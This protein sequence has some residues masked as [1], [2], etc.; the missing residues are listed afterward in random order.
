MEAVAKVAEWATAPA[1]VQVMVPGVGRVTGL[2]V[3]LAMAPRAAWVMA[4]QVGEVTAEEG[5]AVVAMGTEA[6]AMA[7][8]VVAMAGG[9]MELAAALLA[10]PAEET[11]WRHSSVH[12]RIRVSQSH[13]LQSCPDNRSHASHRGDN[14]RL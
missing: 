10:A 4:R 6:V 12:R 8:E 14:K 1:A 3:D 2:A 5:L 13:T 9:V 7:M 11:A